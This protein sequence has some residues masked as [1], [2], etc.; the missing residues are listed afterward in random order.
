MKQKRS[1]NRSKKLLARA[2]RV[3]PR[4]A[5]TLSKAPDQF[6][7]GVSPYA[8]EKGKGCKVW[9][10]DGNEYIDLSSALGASILGYQHPAVEKAVREQRKKGTIF[11]LPGAIEIDLAERLTRMHPFIEMVRFGMN[12]SDA[13]T[14]AVRIARAYTGREHIAKCGYH[15]WADWT[16]ATHPLRSGGIPQAVKNLTH[17][18]KYNDISSLKKLFDEYP[19]NIAAVTLEPTHGTLPKEGFLKEVVELAHKHGAVVVFDE[20]VTG[21]RLAYGGAVEYFDV[22]PDLVCYGKAI[23]NGEPLSVIAGRREI[24][25][26]LDTK[27]IFFSFT[28][29]GYLPSIAAALATLDFM[30]KKK[31]HK[32]LFKRGDRFAKEFDRLA[33]KCGAPIRAS[34]IGPM[35][36]L[37]IGEGEDLPLKTLFLQETAKQGL[38]TNASVILNY[39]HTDAVL[40]DVLRRFEQVLKV[41]GEAVQTNTVSARLEGPLV[42]ARARPSS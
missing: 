17:E 16:I 19:D 27:D 37:K 40:S 25:S 42:R 6:V 2:E 7:R 1:L 24:M 31:I 3:I 38:F 26:V 4:A 41:V 5:Q 14:G 8:I 30:K 15:G 10:A 36:M 18:F 34:G 28:Y 32:E 33:E 23:S 29:A 22:E 20:L 12:G 13:T 35:R 39:A 11:G 9:D 21:F